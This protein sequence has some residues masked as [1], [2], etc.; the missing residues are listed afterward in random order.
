LCFSR[1]HFHPKNI[2]EKIQELAGIF[3]GMISLAF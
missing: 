2:P 3:S 1:P